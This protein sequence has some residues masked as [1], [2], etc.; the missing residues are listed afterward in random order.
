MK[1]RSFAPTKLLV[2][3]LLG[4]VALAPQAFAQRNDIEYGKYLGTRLRLYAEAYE[5][6]DAEISKAKDAAAR[7]RAKQAKAEVMKAEADHNYAE[8]GDMD[9]RMKR[10]ERALGVFEDVTDPAGV[11]AKSVMQ[12]D[13]ARELR[14]GDP[15][16]A[17][18]YCDNAEAALKKSWQAMDEERARID[19]NVFRQ[20]RGEVFNATFYHHCRS[21]YIK[22]LTYDAGSADR[23]HQ[24]KLSEKWIDEFDFLREGETREFVLTY[25][26]RAEIALARG[27]LEGAA[28]GFMNLVNFV[29][30]FPPSSFVG[31]IALE[32]GYLR[33]V[34][35]L[36]TELDYEPRN[37]QKAIDLYA[38]AYS[39]YGQF[40]DL[41]FWF[42][43]FQLFRISALIKQGN[44]S[45]IEGA[46][47]LLFR[48]AKD[49]DA[50]FR[51][52]ALTVLA[53]VAM[54]R[55]LD[56]ETRFKCAET[57][58]SEMASN[59]INVNLKNIQA[60]QALLASCTELRKFE[61][62]APVC[63]LRI[64]DMYSNM[65]RFYDA[66]LAYRDACYRTLYFRDKFADAEDVPAHMK[67]RCE[68]IKDVES[69]TGFPGEMAV[70][71]ARHAGY[72]VHKDLGD[73][74]N[75]EFKKFADEMDQL[76]AAVSGE[77]ALRDLQAKKA[78]E[79]FAA[80]RYPNAAVLFL[81][82]PATYRSYH[83]GLYIAA[84]CYYNLADDANAPRVSR[85]G[86]ED[87]RESAEFFTQQR[88][89]HAA[90]LAQLPKSMWEGVEKAHWDAIDD[91]NTRDSL[92]NWHKAV[93]F[94]KKYFL[95]EVLR[96]WRDIRESLDDV[97][98]PTLIDG[99]RALAEFRNARWVKDNPTGRGEA[100]PDMKRIGYAAYD[101][102][103][104]LR[105]PPKNIPTA[106]RDALSAGGRDLALG[107]LRPFWSMFGYHLAGVEAYQR[108][109][110]R[111]AFGALAEARD[112][113]ACE[114][115]YTTYAEAFPG[116]TDELKSMVNR[117]YGILREQL[118]PRVSAYARASS[119]VSSRS[120]Q[121]KLDQFKRINDKDYPD[122]AK[123]LAEAKT[124]VERQR[125][126]AD[127]FWRVW[128]RQRTF[129]PNDSSPIS[130]H[131][132]E[133]LPT[134]EKRW[135]E[136]A[137]S[138]PSRWA[139]AVEA[140]YKAQIA[141]PK[142]GDGRE[143]Y[144]KDVRAAIEK[145]AAGEKL[146]LL[147]RLHKLRD[148]TTDNNTKQRIV[149]LVTAIE[150]ATNELAY[151]TGTAF[152][153]EFGGFLEQLA[154]DIDEL[155]RPVTTRILKYYELRRTG[156]GGSIDTINQDEL[157]QV[158]PQWF[159]I[160]DWDN[161]I[162]YLEVI[163]GKAK[164][165]WGK[166]EEIPVDGRNKMI[167]RPSNARELEVRF[168]LGKSYL[169]L[170]RNSKNR[171]HLRKA[172]LHLRRCWCFNE[173]RDTNKKL[174]DVY[175]LSFQT[176]IETY[177]LATAD[178]LSEV[179]LELFNIGDMT[180]AWPKYVNQVT[181]DFMPKKEGDKVVLQGVPADKA[182]Y[183][184][185]ASQ[186]RLQVWASFTKLGAYQYRTEFRNNLV[187]WLETMVRWIDTYGLKPPAGVSEKEI[188]QWI[189]DAYTTAKSE[190]SM[191][192]AYLADDTKAYLA[193]VQALEKQI[194]ESC[195][196]ANITLK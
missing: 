174:G 40:S 16:K 36:T 79:H 187:G 25:E 172:A 149:Q 195:K 127:H 196:K 92:A 115:L 186:I 24:L 86:P 105:N 90:D 37:L 19:Q 39:K 113:D 129:D 84:K 178:A 15:N 180:I 181:S 114:Q 176:E 183:L 76:K 123:R 99:L 160:R 70:R 153:Y 9:A 117:V 130:E 133:L 120:A 7:S 103:Y 42:K 73:P 17:R 132:P 155:A 1:N 35:I 171:E 190:G 83:V 58:F 67:D 165:Q 69:L 71:A 100:D 119:R 68:L 136:L 52:Q 5:V 63:F 91:G 131:L 175:K 141:P 177:Y 13:V 94:Y 2:A 107:I 60:Y 54:R 158:A 110:L 46:I 162:R 144:Y 188:A 182:G 111:L 95:V 147:D 78:R 21:F 161:A 18:S 47:T 139:D 3:C 143:D 116:D 145:A 169:E 152:I 148:E 122:D 96:N 51:R 59:H 150:L 56:D 20:T 98:S 121:L 137:N 6:L 167:G 80:K 151:F 30:A 134:I 108:G 34:E 85:A 27:D 23:E 157:E 38:E 65:W 189:Q 32:H 43:R 159:R 4:V 44:K 77:D 109:S 82:L 45:Q 88:Q 10:Y 81:K 74:N 168:M 128:I 101:L 66:A 12:L 11:L 29:S 192:A 140:E 154:A 138:Y 156:S 163:E 72:L 184:W 64:A 97:K 93:Y 8:D 33:A 89:R 28:A 48:L 61:T 75:R 142:A 164:A 22:A 126:L 62:Y 14:R 179:F 194:A 53:D 124:A 26:L 125:A 87:E 102:A 55:E 31:A 173:I 191:K 170:Y 106:E 146:T 49:P 104:L 135:N 57:V 50:A 112:A 193:K 41:E 166:E 118:T 185:F